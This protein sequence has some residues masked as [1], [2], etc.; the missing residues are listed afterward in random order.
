MFIE[1]FR[2]IQFPATRHSR[3]SE[4]VI[5]HMSLDYTNFV[6][7]GLEIFVHG[8]AK[9]MLLMC[10]IKGFDLNKRQES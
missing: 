5:N 1:F 3:V 2:K 6:A 9:L 8:K 4:R 10:C 7:Q